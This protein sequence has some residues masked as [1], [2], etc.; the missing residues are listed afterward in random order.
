MWTLFV[1]KNTNINIM[2]WGITNK[3]N[4][5]SYMT[6]EKLQVPTIPKQGKKVAT[7]VHKVINRNRIR[8]PSH[9]LPQDEICTLSF[10]EGNDSSVM[11]VS[12]TARCASTLLVM[13][14]LCTLPVTA[15]YLPANHFHL[16]QN[17][18]I[19][20]RFYLEWREGSILSLAPLLWESLASP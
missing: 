18:Q 7:M 17:M 8:S 2:T 14:L 20:A 19:S 4:S 11:S 13:L 16:C 1:H 10:R 9:C 3:V 5:H 15:W 6:I 12:K